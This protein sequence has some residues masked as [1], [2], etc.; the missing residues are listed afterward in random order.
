[1]ARRRSA[2]ASA[3]AALVVAA[4]PT[5]VSSFIGRE[6]Q[7]GEV[8]HLLASRRLVTL[9][10]AGGCGKTRLALELAV[11]QRE[12]F[13]HS[14]VFVPLAPLGDPSLVAAAVARA[15]G[16][17]ESAGRS[18]RE[19]VALA[20]RGRE[21][22]LVLDNLEHLLD[23]APLVAE[24]LA[25]CRGRTVLATSRERL[26]LQ[27]EQVYPV[28]PLSLPAAPDADLGSSEALRLFVERA[29]AVEPGFALTPENAAAVAEICR[30]LDALPLAIELAAARV[31]LLPPQAML[32]R[33]E[34]R[35]PLL[36]GGPR[37]LPARQRTLR[38]TIA[39]SH[40][41]LS[42]VEQ[43]LFRRLAVFAGGWT[44][45]AADCVTSADGRL[46]TDDCSSSSIDSHLSCVLDRLA[47]LADK[48]LVFRTD[49]AADEPRFGMLE[50]IREYAAEHLVAQGEE[51]F[52]RQAHARYFLRLAEGAAPALHG[53]DQIAWFDRLEAEH[54]N[55]R[56]ALAWSLETGAVEAALRL[57][58]ALHWFW[59][60]RGHLSEGRSWLEHAL[61]A[62]G[63]D[64]GS[65]AQ[66][67][68]PPTAHLAQALHGAGLL[69]LFQG[70]FPAARARL[71]QA[72][73]AYRA[74]GDR[75]G[76]ALALTFLSAV[77]GHQGERRQRDAVVEEL[78]AL[79]PAVEGTWTEA[80]LLFTWGRA[81]LL[82]GGDTAAARG[83]LEASL[84]RFRALGDT[85]LLA[86]VV[87]DLGEIA[88]AEG[89]LTV[90]QARFE[91]ALTLA[92]AL[93]DPAGVAAM[94]N[95][96]GEL[97]RCRGDD[98]GA[99]A[100]YAESLD[101]YERLGERQDV[102][103]LLHCLGYV[104]LH[105]GESGRAAAL[106]A[107]GLDQFQ[108]LGVE[109]GIPE[110]LAGLAAVA[111]AGGAAGRAARLWGAAEAL[112]EAGGTSP[113]PADR[114]EY[115]R[116][117]PLAR[118][119]LG[120]PA[121]AA[122]WAAGRALAPAAAITEALA[123]PSPPV[124]SESS[125]LPATARGGRAARPGG[126]TEREVEVARL[127]ADG[128][129]NREIAAALVLSERTVAKHLDHIFAK[130]DVSS[131]TAVA[132]FALRHGL[133]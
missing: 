74:L 118:A 88:L 112:H 126:L 77:A 64:A 65:G 51:A 113:W 41:L 68:T 37:D 31:G 111:A 89:D 13:P 76:L 56:G 47:S 85:W 14:V 33:L 109:R 49:L 127:V 6:R 81:A 91:E 98:V 66:H 96:L 103:R 102:T 34:H 28:P 122:A 17:R 45:E 114:G 75:H 86:Q 59:F 82:W 52:V 69:A 67:P 62:A 15:L 60:V 4:L 63:W 124:G 55:L 107:R 71:A 106:F 133:A 19:A 104:A 132:A 108:A 110:S 78:L 105:R 1:V 25:E 8:E 24:W 48:S 20:L 117:L 92:R 116:H 9:T 12:A 79:L 42:E 39:W 93:K 83:R 101:L 36:V 61:G 43:A 21:L 95:N 27:G 125:P 40:E 32:A 53:P 26:R 128:K 115:D 119:A 22:L 18:Y 70:D 58:S 100:L 11:R 130:L 123:E 90:A 46:T 23:A 72:A 131:R 120:E 121:F 80:W 50:T 35:L 2:A 7:L 57:A 84:A 38:D 16:I 10:G 99:E 54:A 44:L 94:L 73:A 29:R 5:P 87:N 129:T 30:R 3:R 97:A